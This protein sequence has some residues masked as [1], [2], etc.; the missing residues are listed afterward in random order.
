MQKHSHHLCC[1]DECSLVY[2]SRQ[3]AERYAS[4]PEPTKAK[5]SQYYESH[6]DKV[7]AYIKQWQAENPE[8]VKAYKEK[9]A[10]NRKRG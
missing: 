2:A 9:N 6:K 3:K 4:N 7:K 1:S 5:V 8:K 10:L